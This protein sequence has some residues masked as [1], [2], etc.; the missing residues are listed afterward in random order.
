MAT[1]DVQLQHLSFVY[2]YLRDLILVAE[3]PNILCTTL[4]KE[5]L[6]RIYRDFEVAS[7][8]YSLSKNLLD[9]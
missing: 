6:Y 4:A 1:F 7:L 3:S 9:R 5:G 8:F 2:I